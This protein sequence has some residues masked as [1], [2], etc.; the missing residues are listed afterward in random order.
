MPNQDSK[1]GSLS[2]QTFN[3]AIAII[4][5]TGLATKPLGFLTQVVIART[6]GATYL[7]DTFGFAAG[8]IQLIIGLLT[9][10]I[11]FVVIPTLI[12]IREKEG[13]EAA[14]N[15][16]NT[17]YTFLA[18]GL[19]GL[20][21]LLG[22]FAFPLV[23]L[24]SNFP[25]S[26]TLL[27]ASLFTWLL[28]VLVFSGLNNFQVSVVQ[29]YKHFTI[30]A[31]LGVFGSITTIVAVFAFSG[32]LSIFSM[33]VAQVSGVLIQFII[34]LL[35]IRRKKP[36]PRFYVNPSQL[37]RLKK[38]SY[39][40]GPLV[41]STLFNIAVPIVMRYIASG[42]QEG[43]ISALN[44]ADYIQGLPYSMLVVSVG[45]VAFPFLATHSARGEW[46]I[47]A[48][49]LNLR[50]RSLWF[51]LL[52]TSAL[53]IG[54]SKP[55]VRILLKRGR[56]DETAVTMTAGVLILSSLGLFA[57]GGHYLVTRTF[58]SLQDTLTPL[59]VGVLFV[60]IEIVLY[61][62]LSHVMG[63]RGLALAQSLT[64]TGTFLA[65][66]YALQRKLG[67]SFQMR[68]G[69]AAFRLIGL[70]AVVGVIAYVTYRIVINSFPPASVVGEIIPTCV[71][72]SIAIL[73][74]LGIAYALKFEEMREFMYVLKIQSNKLR[75]RFFRPQEQPL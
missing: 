6:F 22:V 50:M 57:Q 47:L 67:A 15:L 30:P 56:F 5:I 3:Q 43:T 20:A 73:A 19:V 52:P 40:V 62:A 39:L 60:A 23:R 29:S 25:P 75:Q 8:Q 58:F 65:L 9:D 12:D 55:L 46:A 14:W 17:V 27:A 45:T 13:E 41:L 64:T 74:Y 4:I 37:A 16:A 42:L 53:M 11:P 31:L 24:L 34:V 10:F 28:P 72:A 44:Y 21:V 69:A 59:K 32:R 1:L 54:L 71:A 36:F 26:E 38:L 68:I 51:V 48:H 7:T 70:S 66:Y 61:F 18:F 2:T 49:N 33:V 35:F 63:Y